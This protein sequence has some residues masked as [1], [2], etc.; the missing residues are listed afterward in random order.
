MLLSQFVPPSPSSVVS[1]NLLSIY[2]YP[3]SFFYTQVFYRKKKTVAEKFHLGI[4][5]TIMFG[6]SLWPMVI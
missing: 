2:M 1:T 5:K 6:V 3:F 4:G